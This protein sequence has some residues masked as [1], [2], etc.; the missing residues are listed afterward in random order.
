[1]YVLFFFFFSSRR[2]HT[3]FDC[4]WSSD[5][6]SSDLGARLLVRRRPGPGQARLGGGLQGE[7]VQ[8]LGQEVS[9]HAGPRAPG[10]GAAA[11]LGLVWLLL[12]SGPPVGVTVGRVTA[13]AW[14]SQQALAV[15]L[16]QAADGAA[17]FPGVGLLPDRPIRVIL[18]PTPAT[19]DSLT[20][21]RLPRGSEGAA[22]PQAGT[23]RMMA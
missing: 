5:V 7:Q 15:E 13:V 16:A 1:M 8:S 21:G 17:P 3:R 6:C 9:G 11:H 23:G 4:D 10:T 18:A 2:R 20:R 22:F 14:P 19:F 12:Q